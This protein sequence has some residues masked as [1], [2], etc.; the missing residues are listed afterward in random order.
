MEFLVRLTPRFPATQTEAE[1][2]ALLAAERARGSELL[3]A[4]KVR[5]M[6][7]LPGTTSALLLWDVESPDEL[8]S[9]LSSMPAWQYC[10]VE[11]T[12]VMQHP[13][14]A[15]VRGASA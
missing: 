12:T 15:A 5:R 10:D 2:T 14:E 1:R 11:V 3:A 7:R 13:V 9:L 4:G 6:W 8:H